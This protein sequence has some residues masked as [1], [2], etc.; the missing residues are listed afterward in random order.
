MT[1]DGAGRW[2]MELDHGPWTMDKIPPVG[3]QAQIK[4]KDQKILPRSFTEKRLKKKSKFPST[5]DGQG[6]CRLLLIAE[7]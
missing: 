4:E 3:G 2:T 1:D 7:S 6:G 5:N